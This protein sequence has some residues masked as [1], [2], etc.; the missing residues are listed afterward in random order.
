[1]LLLA[2]PLALGALAGRAEP[3]EAPGVPLDRLLKLP[4]SAPVGGSLEKR[5][6]DTKREWEARYRTAR[7]DLERA[8]R[9]LE[10]TRA[11]LEER[12]GEEG[13]AWRMSPPGLGG[14]TAEA[15]D[16]TP[17]DY[18]LTQDLR[19][20]REEVARSER[21]LQDLDVEANLAGVPPD[22]RGAEPASAEGARSEPQASEGRSPSASD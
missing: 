1:V 9:E 15:S 18:K 4:A 13:G 5:G 3:D 22:W 7:E 12:A 11:E 21:R 6:G 10:E 20:R 16:T 14:A 17:I 2:A 8:R 19:R